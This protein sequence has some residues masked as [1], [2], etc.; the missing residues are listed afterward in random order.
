MR[1]GCARHSLSLCCST[2]DHLLYVTIPF[3]W[4]IKR[5]K[6]NC[7]LFYILNHNTDTVKCLLCTVRHIVLQ[8]HILDVIN[9]RLWCVFSG[10]RTQLSVVF[11]F[12]KKLITEC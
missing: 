3:F 7:V 6:V 8:D 11:F 2:I 1:T 5:Y 12:L 4:H 10:R 9:E